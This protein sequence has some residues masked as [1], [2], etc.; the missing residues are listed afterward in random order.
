MI[1]TL[2]AFLRFRNETILQ[3]EAMLSIALVESCGGTDTTI[4]GFNGFML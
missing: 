2:T 3:L 4:I 1:M